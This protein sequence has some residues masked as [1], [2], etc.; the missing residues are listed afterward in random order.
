MKNKSKDILKINSTLEEK[1]GN[2]APSIP[3][4]TYLSDNA[5][6]SQLYL[7]NIKKYPL[8]TKDQ[9][10]K[11]ALRVQ[12]GDKE[13][14]DLMINSNLGLVI[15]VAKRFL[16]R[17]L[18]FDDLVMEGNIGLIKGVDRF[19]PKKGFRFSTYAVWWI[20]Q[21]IERG[22]LNSGRL[23]RLPIH[24][25][26][27]IFKYSRSFREM[28]SELEREPHV[29]EVAGRMGIKEK[30]LDAVLSS[31]SSIYSID[32]SNGE[33]GTGDG[34]NLMLGNILKDDEETTSPLNILCK[35]ELLTLLNKWLLV[36][37]DQEKNI[38]TLRYGLNNERQQTLNEIGLIFNLTK[39]R[40]RQ[41]EVKAVK[42]LKKIAA[43][44]KL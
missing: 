34:Q 32:V 38:I 17:G 29:S 27:N 11:L 7:K 26:E 33:N 37:D 10:Y 25:S 19:L 15:T 12:N 30:K 40:I 22:I 2:G 13:A 24:I 36:L 35:M 18:S 21:S 16:G 14:R 31:I 41:I 4:S 43:E 20:R 8:L 39:E 28:Q 23:I 6:V 3:S 5:S 42:K 1:D 9:E 44:S